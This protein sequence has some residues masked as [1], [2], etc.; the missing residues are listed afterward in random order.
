M[1]R[2]Q[3]GL[4]I[5]AALAVYYF[6]G[7]IVAGSQKAIKAVKTATR[8]IRNNNPG[9]IERGATKW[10]GMSADQ[11]GDSRFAVFTSPEYGIRALARILGTYATAHG[12][13][14]VAGIVNRWAPPGE[15]DTGAYARAV[16][17]ALR[18]SPTEKIDVK[19]RLPELVTAIIKHENGYNPYSQSQITA[20]VNAA[21][22]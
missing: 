9:N 10:Q 12:L 19:S 8:G 5:V 3:V 13:N 16:A 22:V 17:A 6:R 2:Q 4:L 15:N 1:N 7:T 20:G 11:S 18:V 21:K 14:T